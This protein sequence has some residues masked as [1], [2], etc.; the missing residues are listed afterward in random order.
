MQLDKEVSHT[1]SLYHGWTT[2][3][4]GPAVPLCGAFQT[5]RGVMLRCPGA[6][7]YDQGGNTVNTVPIWVGRSNRVTPDQSDTGGMPLVPGASMFIPIDDP[8]Q[9]FIISV[10]AGQKVAWMGV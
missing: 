10:A 1:H 6:A 7:D 5:A 9:I 4:T 8:S 3:G 2:V